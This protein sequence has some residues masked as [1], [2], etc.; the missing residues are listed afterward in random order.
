M[1]FIKKLESNSVKA[2]DL[3]DEKSWCDCWQ[4]TRFFFSPKHP[5]FFWGLLSLLFVGNG[6]LALGAKQPMLVADL[7]PLLALRLGINE[8]LSPLLHVPLRCA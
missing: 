4:G 8:A 2:I 5:E 1:M 3:T 7:S 6:P